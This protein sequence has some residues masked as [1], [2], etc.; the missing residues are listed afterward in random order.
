MQLYDEKIP[1]KDAAQGP[2]GSTRLR[3]DS[4]GTDKTWNSRNVTAGGVEH[5]AG[6]A[7]CTFCSKPFTGNI[8]KNI[9]HVGV[10]HNVVDDYLAPGYRVSK[11]NLKS[12]EELAPSKVKEEYKAK[13]DDSN[14]EKL[15]SDKAIL[16][17]EWS[18]Q[19]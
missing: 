16:F 7:A 13:V 14:V 9:Q 18:I 6:K 19:A 15:E 2:S 10:T 5:V 8:N 3:I 12:K 17:N 11:L 1:E 4:L